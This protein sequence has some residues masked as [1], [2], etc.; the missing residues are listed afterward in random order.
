MRWNTH[1]TNPKVNARRLEKYREIHAAIKHRKPNPTMESRI[2][3]TE[4]EDIQ[5]II[6][7]YRAEHPNPNSE[8][9]E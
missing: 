6:D 4:E 2:L 1:K 9:P 7:A 3:R 8:Q 5:S